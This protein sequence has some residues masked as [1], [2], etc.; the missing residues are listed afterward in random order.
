[1]EDDDDIEAIRQQ[2][3]NH[4]FDE[5]QF[6]V[7]ADKLAEYAKACGE[8]AS[9]FIN[10]D[11][12]DF[13]ALPTFTSSLMGGRSR[14]KGFPTF[15]GIGMDGGKAVE[16]LKPIR[17]GVT[18]TG[19]SH[20]HDIYTKTGRSGRMIFLISRMEVYD[21]QGEHLANADTRI[22]IRERAKD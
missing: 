14:P 1:M 3:L 8:T 7:E 4:E 15:G 22:V 17:P 13:Q 21:P 2:Y 10:P 16:P 6:E 19:K 9:R 20:I 12:P 11:D 5:K 18:L